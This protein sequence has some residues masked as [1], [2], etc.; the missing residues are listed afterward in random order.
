MNGLYEMLLF[1][2]ILGAA[3][4][5]I[6]ELGMFDMTIPETGV[7][8][9][10][11][12]QVQ[13]LHSGAVSTGSSDYSTI[14]IV[15]AFMKVIGMGIVAMFTIVPMVV[16]WGTAIGCPMALVLIFGGIL[17]APIT[18]VTLFGLWEFWTGR[19]AS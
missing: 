16:Q 14:E 5:G 19:P 11:E 4:Q 13:E 7:D 15:L 10:G 17:Q 12:E 3:T 9:I 18:Y 1:L 8:S 6:N 2:F